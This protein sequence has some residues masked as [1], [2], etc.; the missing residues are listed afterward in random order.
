VSSANG[1]V[2]VLPPLFTDNR[3]APEGTRKMSFVTF[4]VSGVWFMLVGLGLVGCRPP[5]TPGEPSSSTPVTRA[6]VREEM[7]K[8]SGPEEAE[9]LAEKGRASRRFHER[10]VEIDQHLAALKTRIADLPVAEQEVWSARMALLEHERSVL[11]QWVARLDAATKKE[12][13]PLSNEAQQAFE[14]AESAVLKAADEL[15][16]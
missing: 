13:H 1:E 6:Q 11:A 9:F 8:V 7:S 10:L 4:R 15:G 2:I 3:A 12:W 16:S 14:N 5:A